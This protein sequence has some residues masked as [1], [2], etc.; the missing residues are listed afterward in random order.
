MTAPRVRLA[1]AI[2]DMADTAA[3]KWVGVVLLDGRDQQSFTA[4]SRAEAEILANAFDSG[5]R[6]W[7]RSAG[8]TESCEAFHER[9]SVHDPRGASEAKDSGGRPYRYRKSVAFVAAPSAS[10]AQFVSSGSRAARAVP[11]VGL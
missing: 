4:A 1:A 8:S 9:L 10:A 6:D 5:W 2:P 7:T 11:A 3:S